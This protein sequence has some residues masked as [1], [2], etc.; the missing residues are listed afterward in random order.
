ML[1]K[2]LLYS[3]SAL[4]SPIEAASLVLTRPFSGYFI[5]KSRH[6]SSN[7]LV[8]SDFCQIEDLISHTFL[9]GIHIFAE[10]ASP[11]VGRESLGYPCLGTEAGEREAPALRAGSSLRSFHARASGH[12]I[13]PH[14]TDEGQDE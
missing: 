12:G 4:S 9:S 6:R 3:F 2:N 7:E 14:F 5:K 13:L 10:T 1:S 11:P 8:L